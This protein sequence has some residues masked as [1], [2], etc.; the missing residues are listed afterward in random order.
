MRRY[1]LIPEFLGRFPIVTHTNPLKVE[2]LIKILTEPKNAITKQYQKLLSVDNI[3]LAFSKDALS[4]I[5]NIAINNKTGARGLRKI[6]ENVLTDIMFEYGG[7]NS[8]VKKV[9][10]DNKYLMKY[11]PDLITDNIDKKKKAA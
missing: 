10:I 3:N 2:D 9:T 6:I 4:T 1:G 11:Y 5:A 7:T 8:K